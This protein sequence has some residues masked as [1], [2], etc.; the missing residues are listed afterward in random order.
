MAKKH[1]SVRIDQDKL[2]DFVEAYQAYRKELDKFSNLPVEELT[3]TSILEFAL[4]YG[5]E[6]LKTDTNKLKISS[7]K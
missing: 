2:N 4:F 7:E 5:A 6:Q 3:M 1:I